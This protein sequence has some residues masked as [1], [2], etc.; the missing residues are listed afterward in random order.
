MKQVYM[1]LLQMKE[2]KAIP[3]YKS[4]LNGKNY[5]HF[6]VLLRLF[7]PHYITAHFLK[8]KKA[9]ITC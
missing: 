4:L 2:N 3:N 7:I 9:G 6:V 8:I 5:Q 1:T